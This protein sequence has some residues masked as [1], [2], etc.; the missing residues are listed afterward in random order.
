MKYAEVKH[1]LE[2]RPFRPFVIV[3][4]NGEQY[5]VHH[6]ELAWNTLNAVLIYRASSED[7]TV[8]ESWLATCA[9]ENISVI[10]PLREAAA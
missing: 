7:E 8:P 4:N 9:M 10:K 6:P 1:A 2:E 5:E 3:M